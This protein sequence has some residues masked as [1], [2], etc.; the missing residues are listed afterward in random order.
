MMPRVKVAFRF[1]IRRIHHIAMTNKL[2][3]LFDIDNFKAEAEGQSIVIDLMDV[4][5]VDHAVV[6]F[7]KRCEAR[8]M[9]LANCPAYIRE[10]IV[11]E[12]S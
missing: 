7:L 9:K 5:L 6:K 11:R 2:V 4:K 10:W 12:R 3:F 1:G 8:G